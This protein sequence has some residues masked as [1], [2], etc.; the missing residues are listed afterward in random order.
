MSKIKK[1][2]VIGAGVMGAGIAAHITNAGIPC[3]LLDIP[4]K[5]KTNKNAVANNAIKALLKT[6]PASFMSKKNA[7]LITTGNI[8]DNFDLIS[9]CDWIIEAIIE[10]LGLKK[11]LYHKISKHRKPKSIVS[12]NTSTIP[13]KE[14]ISD[15]DEKLRPY[16]LIT[17]FFNPPRYMKLLEIVASNY[18]DRASI[19]IIKKVCDVHLGKTVIEAKDTPGFIANRIGTFWFQ[20]GVKTAIELNLKVEEADAITSK[21]FGIPKSGVFGTLDLVGLDLLPHIAASMLERLPDQDNYRDIYFEAPIITQ[22]LDKGWIGRKGPSGFYRLRKAGTTK[23]KESID[24]KDGTYSKS[25]KPSLASL[26][27]ARSE[28]LLGLLGHEDK[29]GRFAWELA[30]KGLL[31]AASLI[32]QIADT[33]VDIDV[34]MKEGYGWKY[35]P[36]EIIDKIGVTQ[37]VELLRNTSITIPPIILLAAQKQGFYRIENGNIQFLNVDGTYHDIPK[38][39][40][41]ISLKDIKLNSSPILQNKSAKVWD[42]DDGVVCFEFT[43]KLNSLDPDTMNLYKKTIKY[44]DSTDKQIALVIYNE[45]DHFSAGANLGLFLYAAN[46]AM[47]PEIENQIEDGQETY[48]AI[49]QASF[50]VVAAPAG[51]ALGGGCEILLHADAIQAHAETYTGLVEVGV[52][53]VPS[54]GGCKE[55]LLRFS[56]DPKMPKGPMP[57]IAKAFELIGMARVSTSAIEAKELGILS[58]S[59]GI[60]M[61]RNR[62]LKDAKE[63]ALSLVTNYKP[64]EEAALNLPGASGRAAIKTILRDM[65]LKGLLTPHDKVV[66]EELSKVLTGHETDITESL[67]ESEV[68]EL[69]KTAFINL[70]RT[71]KTLNRI[72][73]M[74]D[75]GKPLR[76]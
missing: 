27:T 48:M 37:F 39:E 57:S 13:L 67:T 45:A 20:L 46:L 35:G 64:P 65:D 47:W 70:A 49:K 61:N 21:P 24:L 2:A 62:L 63:K 56:K 43:S 44:I 68:L 9:D 32:T 6:T 42:L 23:I 28:G 71:N 3:I 31:Y 52:G 7:K 36:F 29:G 72:E 11:E 58:E 38:H 50:P 54:W 14:L 53:L 25:I 10:N 26:N 5:T 41:I 51:M 22:M 59:D 12:S 74:L 15:M 17:H 18:S 34:A 30:S 66:T 4:A 69:E 55:M 76:N 16:F 19:E 40:D 73:S 33:V 75:T 60:T 1:V 8:E